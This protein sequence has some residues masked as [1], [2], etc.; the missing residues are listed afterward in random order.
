[1]EPVL[2]IFS[3]VLDPAF[4]VNPDPDRDP[5]PDSILIHG[6]DTKNCWKESSRK[7]FS[8][9]NCNYLCRSHRRRLQPSKENI[10]HFK[11]WNLL[12]FFYVC[13]GNFC[14]PDPDCESGFGFG[15]GSRDPIESGSN[16]DP[17]LINC[18]FLTSY[19]WQWIL[20]LSFPS[21]VRLNS[22]TVDIVG[23]KRI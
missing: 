15:Y 11:K 22:C 10:Q 21:Y 4:Q 8:I 7:L 17:D 20:S 23:Q 14:P 16:T 5:D 6:F 2:H 19:I 1:M 9:E 18:F 3:W 13:V 12:I